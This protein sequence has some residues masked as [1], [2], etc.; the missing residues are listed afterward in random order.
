M[1]II[2]RQAGKWGERPPLQQ[3]SG[4]TPPR[5]CALC[6]NEFFGVFYSTDP[7]GF[8]DIAV[9][10]DTVTAM[11]VNRAALETYVAAHPEL[12]A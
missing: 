9:E 6:P 10:G 2:E 4:K 1:Y 8:V 7:A 11:T 3:W 12:D 5:G